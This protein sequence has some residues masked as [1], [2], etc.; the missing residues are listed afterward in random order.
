MFNQ[1]KIYFGKYRE[2]LSPDQTLHKN[3]FRIGFIAGFIIAFLI[4]FIVS[5]FILYP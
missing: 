1:E 5:L 2:T 4:V 3:I